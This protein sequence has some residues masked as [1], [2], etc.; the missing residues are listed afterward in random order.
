MS[1]TLCH[2]ACE[3]L[4]TRHGVFTD[5]R[6]RL[7]EDY[8]RLANV[9]ILLDSLSGGIVGDAL[10]FRQLVDAKLSGVGC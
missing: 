1:A 6:A 4:P 5:L 8:I 2:S 3:Y 10:G 7:A 9:S